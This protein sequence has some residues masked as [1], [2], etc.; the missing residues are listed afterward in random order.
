MVQAS[1]VGGGE[2][3]EKG[4]DIKIRLAQ[5]GLE[6]DINLLDN[7]RTRLTEMHVVIMKLTEQ[8][9]KLI[10]KLQEVDQAGGLLSQKERA[11]KDVEKLKESTQRLKLNLLEME[12]QLQDKDS[13]LWE[14]KYDIKDYNT[15]VQ[16]LEEK[17]MNAV[18]MD[19]D[20]G[21]HGKTAFEL[22]QEE[23]I[24]D[25]K[26][27][28]KVLAKR[29]EDLETELAARSQGPSATRSTGRGSRV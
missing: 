20:P 8:N 21:L 9:Q 23:S 5:D 29:I 22:A 3:L 24:K 4:K 28:K 18:S 12:E 16:W 26:R 11:E 14:Q 19:E 10:S 2:A 25:L 1:E 7:V 13:I 6:T 27:E 17:L 15:K